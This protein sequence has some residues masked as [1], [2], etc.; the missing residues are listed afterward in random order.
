MWEVLYKYDIQKQTMIGT[1]LVIIASSPRRRR[2]WRQ[3][4]GTMGATRISTWIERNMLFK[5]CVTTDQFQYRI[6]YQNRVHH[7]PLLFL[8]LG[9]ISYRIPGRDK[10]GMYK[11]QWGPSGRNSIQIK[12]NILFFWCFRSILFFRCFGSGEHPFWILGGDDDGMCREQWAQSGIWSI[13]KRTYSSFDA[14]DQGDVH[15]QF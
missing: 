6:C 3:I 11:E 7:S 8:L 12:G 1:M 15:S 9:S 5:I 4:H 2:W 13:S 14:L 10:Y